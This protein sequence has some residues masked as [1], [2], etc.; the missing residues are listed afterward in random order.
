MY[1]NETFY[2]CVQVVKMP[3]TR[4]LSRDLLIDIM[5]ALADEMSTKMCSD[6]STHHHLSSPTVHNDQN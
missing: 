6:I 1:N 4:T 3:K 5:E 2:V